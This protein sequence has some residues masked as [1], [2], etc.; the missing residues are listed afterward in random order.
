MAEP[1]STT[2]D[3]AA[4]ESDGDAAGYDA[5]EAIVALYVALAARYGKE[6]LGYAMPDVVPHHVFDE[7]GGEQDAYGGKY[8]QQ[9][10]V[11]INVETL[12]QEFVN[13]FDEPFQHLGGQ[14]GQ[15]AHHEGQHQGALAQAEVILRPLDESQ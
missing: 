11:L 8:K 15:D 2:G 12:E 13:F 1:V 6:N 10:I 5:A 7:Q 14:G 3:S 4:A 9:P